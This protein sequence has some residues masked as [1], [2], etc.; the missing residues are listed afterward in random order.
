MPRGTPHFWLEQTLIRDDDQAIVC[1][2]RV[3]QRLYG[4][5][6]FVFLAGVL[7]VFALITVPVVVPGLPP[8]YSLGSWPLFFS[9]ACVLAVLLAWL[10]SLSYTLHLDLERRTYQ[11]T[12]G[13]FPLALVRRGP[14]TDINE[15]YV[16]RSHGNLAWEARVRTYGVQ[17]SWKK[18]QWLRRSKVARGFGWVE[19]SEVTLGLSESLAEAEDG[20][21]ELAAKL[22]VPFTGTRYPLGTPKYNQIP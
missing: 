14:L 12:R 20:G 10:F 5:V 11:M 19:E 15:V 22:G 2:T 18:M 1:R 4:G 8:R 9:G 21:R 3:G 7:L 17:L 13:P 6:F 16:L